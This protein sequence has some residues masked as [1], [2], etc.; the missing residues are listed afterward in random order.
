MALRTGHGQ[1]A[2]S[3]RVEVLPANELPAG[4]PAP[5]RE[6]SPSDRGKRGKFARGNTLASAGGRSRAGKTRLATQLGLSSVVSDPT[7][8]QYKT[9]AEAFKRAQ[10][11]SLAQ[12]VGAGYV[13]PGPASIVAS[14]SLQLAASR[15]CFDRGEHQLG[16]KLANDSRQNLLA[17]F[18][19]VAKE[20][21]AKPRRNPGLEALHAAARG[22]EPST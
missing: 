13:G 20:A 9:A 7:F 2:G 1:G 11:A 12:S 6:Q 18:E 21:K 8:R 14:A 17:A 19:L 3:P 4:V 16:S 5:A 22:E 10:V 15:W